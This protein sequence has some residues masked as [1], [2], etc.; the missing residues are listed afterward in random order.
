M[1]LPAGSRHRPALRSR[2]PHCP[3]PAPQVPTAP[4]LV[5]P[6]PHLLGR[7]RHST[8]EKPAWA[9]RPPLHAPASAR[10][11]KRRRRRRTLT[12]PL[13]LPLPVARSGCS[14]AAEV[15]FLRINR[16]FF[17]QNK[18][19][20]R[21]SA[22]PPR[23]W[24]QGWGAAWGCGGP[25]WGTAAARTASRGAAGWGERAPGMGEWGGHR[26]TGP[27][28]PGPPATLGCRPAARG[29]GHRAPF[30]LRFGGGAAGGT[31]SVALAGVAALLA[32]HLVAV[33]HGAVVGDLH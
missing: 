19:K 11:R 27:T 16:F 7:P 8:I 14:S 26:V 23:G 5:P 4:Q 32:L 9:E 2:L 22:G 15:Y 24:A 10:S 17:L 31:G 29:G 33:L 21:P 12:V 1:P 6:V 25:P 3:G 28:P 30:A 18:Y 13:P 20:Q